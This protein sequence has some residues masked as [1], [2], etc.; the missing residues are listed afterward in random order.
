MSLILNLLDGLTFITLYEERESLIMKQSSPVHSTADHQDLRATWKRFQTYLCSRV[1]TAVKES[2]P[3]PKCVFTPFPVPQDGQV[4]S[5]FRSKMDDLGL[6]N[7]LDIVNDVF[8]LWIKHAIIH[9]TSI[10]NLTECFAFLD[11]SH[12]PEIV[13]NKFVGF[14]EFSP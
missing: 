6:S 12:M 9:K 13:H 10:G 14:N 1:S 8:H 3:A 4:N 11:V 5:P 7:D 2:L